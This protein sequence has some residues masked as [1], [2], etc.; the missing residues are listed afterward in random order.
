LVLSTTTLACTPGDAFELACISGPGR[1][2]AAG[3]VAPVVPPVAAPPVAAP[4][5]APVTVAS[6]TVVAEVVVPVVVVL[7]VAVLAAVVLAAVVTGGVVPD[8]VLVL[9]SAIGGGGTTWVVT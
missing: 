2:G 7:D 1:I 5:V 8:G 4:P 9:L 6:A 3:P